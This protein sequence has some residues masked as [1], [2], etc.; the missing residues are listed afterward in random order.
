MPRRQN[1]L[2]SGAFLLERSLSEL[3]EQNP[4]VLNPTEAKQ[5]RS[6]VNRITKLLPSVK[7]LAKSRQAQINAEE[8][9]CVER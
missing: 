6:A 5:L 1:A 9:R 8:L 3:L 2:L 7:Q 4:D